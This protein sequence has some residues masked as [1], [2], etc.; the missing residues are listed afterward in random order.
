MLQKKSLNQMVQ[1]WY[2]KE[3]TYY[4]VLLLA[5]KVIVKVLASI[6]N[7]FSRGRHFTLSPACEGTVTPRIVKLS[8]IF[9]YDFIVQSHHFIGDR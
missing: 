2:S 3:Q 5:F 6:K 4:G 9:C 8:V 1:N 7:S